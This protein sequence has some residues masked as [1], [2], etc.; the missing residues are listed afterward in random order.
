VHFQAVWGE[1]YRTFGVASY[2]NLPAD[3]YAAAVE[4]LDAWRAAVLKG[5]GQG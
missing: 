3:Q 1:L 5:T 2:R 4:F